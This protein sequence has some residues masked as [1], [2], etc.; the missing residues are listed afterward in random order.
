MTIAGS[1]LDIEMGHLW[2]HLDRTQPFEEARWKPGWKQC[3]QVRRL[4]R[5]R[6]TADLQEQV[7]AAVDAAEDARER[8]NDVVHQDWLLRSRDAMR[9]VAEIA[10]I[11]PEDVATYIEEWERESKDSED[12]LSVPRRSIQ[13]VPAQPLEELRQI[14]RALADATNQVTALTFAVASSRETGRPPGFVH[15][16]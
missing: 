11:A 5:E 16:G 6:L 9:P 7:L 12:W 13:P 10:Q 15:P 8:R 1:R 2:H 3:E 4:A 14:E